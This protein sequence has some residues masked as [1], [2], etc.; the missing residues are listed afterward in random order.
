MSER[1]PQP[2]KLLYCL[3]AVAAVLL[4]LYAV[5]PAAKTIVARLT[6]ETVI[7]RESF[8]DQKL[9][10]RCCCQDEQLSDLAGGTLHILA[11]E[12][13]VAFGSPLRK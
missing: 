7:A 10:V 3:L 5:Y 11:G 4:C 13:R 12:E 6:V 2:V 1:G 8:L 9:A